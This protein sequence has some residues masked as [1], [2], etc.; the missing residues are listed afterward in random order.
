V[1]PVYAGGG[2]CGLD[3]MRTLCVLCHAE[4]TARQARSRSAKRSVADG[5]RDQS[6]EDGADVYNNN[7][8]DAAGV[9]NGDQR[10]LVELGVRGRQPGR[11]QSSEVGA[12]V[13]IN[14]AVRDVDANAMRER[15]S[16]FSAINQ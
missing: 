13:D 8:G 1:V 11:T 16:F 14:A 5:E 3:N 12:D 9:E 10:R 6:M 4:V 7:E 2:E 15:H